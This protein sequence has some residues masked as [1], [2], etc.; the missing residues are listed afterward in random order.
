MS[1]M[2]SYSLL[3]NHFCQ[4]SAILSCAIYILAYDML[5]NSTCVHAYVCC[6]QCSFT[7]HTIYILQASIHI[8]CASQT[9]LYEFIFHSMLFYMSSY[10]TFCP[11]PHTTYT[12]CPILHDLLSGAILN[13]CL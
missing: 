12:K 7:L 8:A 6:F 9:I 2:L 5:S 4:C 13:Q 3:H 10:V 1:C 11:T